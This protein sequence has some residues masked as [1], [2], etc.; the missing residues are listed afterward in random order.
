M[1]DETRPKVSEKGQAEALARQRRQAEA[2]RANLAR[3]KNQSRA[4]V[5]DESGAGAE[6][7]SPDPSG[8]QDPQT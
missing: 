3:R 7:C 2:L 1:S 4:R 5:T 6:A 8:L